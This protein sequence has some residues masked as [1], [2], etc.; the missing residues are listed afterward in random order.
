MTVIVTL[1]TFVVQPHVRANLSAWLWGC[2]F[3]LLAVGGLAGVRWNLAGKS[4]ANAFYASCAYVAGMLTSMAFGIYPMVLPARDSVHSLTV[5]SAKAG[6]YGLKV[7]LVWWA[8]GMMLAALYFSIAYR[9][10]VG[11]VVAES[12]SRGR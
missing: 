7:G 8:I 1:V 3:P 6:A 5:N 2:I 10:F 11:R 12:D 9:S 4:E